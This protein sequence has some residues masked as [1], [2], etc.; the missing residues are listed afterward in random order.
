MNRV[1]VDNW[2]R[3]VCPGDRVYY[4]GDFG[5][6]PKCRGD[7]LIDIR[8]SLNGSI[9]FIKGNH[10]NLNKIKKIAH[11]NDKV[12]KN[13]ITTSF[14]LD[15]SVVLSHRPIQ[16]HKWCQYGAR[17]ALCGHVHGEW[18]YHHDF[19]SVNV[20][21]DVWDYAPIRLSVVI[22]LWERENQDE[23]D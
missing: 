12:F 8:K 1:L 20:G 16:Y 5:F 13:T 19:R 15:C 9:S 22:D 4:L 14:H 2:N 23:E 7:L 3:V 6:D 17:Y 21:I 10:D 11:P 18:K